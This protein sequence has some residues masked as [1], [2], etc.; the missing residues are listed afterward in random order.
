MERRFRLP[1]FY[2]DASPA[3][4]KKVREQYCE[5]QNYQSSVWQHI[6]SL[7][8]IPQNYADFLLNSIPV[9]L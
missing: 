4:R 7:S 1:I 8:Y 3:K 9:V 2:H 6:T 5:D